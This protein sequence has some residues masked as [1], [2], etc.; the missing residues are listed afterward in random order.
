MASRKNP[1]VVGMDRRDK[2][3]QMIGDMHDALYSLGD[4]IRKPLAH[5]GD[6]LLP[7]ELQQHEKPEAKAARK[8]VEKLHRAFKGHKGK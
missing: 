4:K 5:D 1:T 6:K 3:E 7:V 2:H 8:H